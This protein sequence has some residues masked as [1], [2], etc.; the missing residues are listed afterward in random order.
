MYLLAPSVYPSPDARGDAVPA[1]VSGQVRRRRRP[2]AHW[3]RTRRQ[4]K[5]ARHSPTIFRPT[6]ALIINIVRVNQI[7]F[8]TIEVFSQAQKK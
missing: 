3:G 7:G 6:L 5:G 2:E 4:S 8:Y 1:G